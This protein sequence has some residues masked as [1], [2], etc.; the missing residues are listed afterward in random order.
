MRSSSTLFIVLAS[1]AVAACSS[2]REQQTHA[3]TPTAAPISKTPSS[4]TTPNPPKLRLPQSVRP[5]SYAVAMRMSPKEEKFSGHVE[6]EVEIGEPTSVIWMHAGENL[7]IQSANVSNVGSTKSARVSRAKEELVALVFDEVLKPGRHTVNVRYDG[8]L[9]SHDGRGAYRQEER[10]DWYVFTQFESTDARR[11]FP[12]FDEPGFKTPWQI[13][14]DVPKDQLAFANT[15][16]TGEKVSPDG[17]KTVTFAPSKPLPSYLVA[18]A[19]GPFEIVDAGKAGA[20]Q[21]PVR[22]IVPKGRSSEA[23]YAAETTGQLVERL[24]KYFGIPYPY[25]KVDHIA[26]P[27]KGGAMENPGL[28]TYGTSTILGKPEDKSIRLQRGYLSIAAHEL[29]HIW[30]GDYVTTAWWDD[31]WLNEAFATWISAKIVDAWHPEWDGAVS[32]VQSKDGVMG[33]D[34]LVSARRIRQPIESKHDIANAFDGITYQKGGAVISMFEAFVGEESFR[35]GVHDYLERHAHGNATAADFLSDVGE[36][37]KRAAVQPK[38]RERADAFAS[39]FSTF[40]DQPGVPMITAELSCEKNATPK[41]LLSQ[42]RYLPQGSQGS[43][44]QTWK[45]P[46]C[47]SYPGGKSCMLMTEANGELPLAD[48]KACPAWVNPNAGSTGYYRA[49]SKTGDAHTGKAADK[50]GGSHR[51]E[52]DVLARLLKE[53]GLAVHE[54]LGIFGDALAFVRNG[55][56]TEGEV[57]SLVPGLVQEGNRHLVGRTIGLVSGLSDHLVP[58]ELGPNYRRF[59]EKVYLPRAKQLGWQSKAGVVED[60]ATRL[61]RPG[62]LALVSRDERSEL[63]MEAR[64][65]TEAWLKDRKAIEH[66]LVGTVLSVAGRHADR[67]LW[68]KLHEAAKKTQDRKERAQLLGAMGSVKDPQLVSKNLEIVLS[69]E[70]DPRETLSLIGGAQDDAKTRQM[71]YDF[72]KANFDRIVARMPKDWGAWLMNVAAD[73]CDGEHRADAEAFFTNKANHLNGGPRT[74]AQVLEGITLCQAQRS[75]RQASVAAFLRKY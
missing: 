46:V 24:E 11:A 18:F 9:P 75:E 58:D 73:F 7:S 45:V 10:G 34:S 36:S 22:I 2:P 53:K 26:V 17:W 47:A 66:D 38:D 41:L 21:V 68:D 31:I 70:F 5:H 72:V 63:S 43:S 62:L 15:P 52:A 44:E 6:V 12:C 28:I 32:R 60:D 4:T 35:K 74:L 27:Q 50:A 42:Q 67:A 56:L 8:T 65:L 33:S 37:L 23:K 13:T 30:F 49:L 64:R 57:L 54:R 25:E 61:L 59:I 29:G 48:A 20:K 14:L 16:Q 1:A 71:A 55:R 3:A 19:V 51:A 40:L 69:D 39:A